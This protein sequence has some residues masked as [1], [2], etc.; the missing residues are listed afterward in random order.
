[1]Q[2]SLDRNYN[3]VLLRNHSRTDSEGFQHRHPNVRYYNSLDLQQSLPPFGTSFSNQ[4]RDKLSSG[5][6]QAALSTRQLAKQSKAPEIDHRARISEI[7]IL[8]MQF[9]F[10]VIPHRRL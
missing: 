3:G 8:E 9:A 2:P 7:R 6:A 10:P 5:T 1:M 4:R